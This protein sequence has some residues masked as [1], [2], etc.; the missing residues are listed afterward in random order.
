MTALV[1]LNEAKATCL[2]FPKRIPRRMSVW[3]P[4]SARHRSRLRC[5]C[6]ASCG[7]RSIRYGP[8]SRAMPVAAGVSGELIIEITSGEDVLRSP[9]PCARRRAAPQDGM[10]WP[11]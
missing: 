3:P 1:E 5:I 6:G 2:E 4:Q 10:P 11:H 9:R 8:G 7:M